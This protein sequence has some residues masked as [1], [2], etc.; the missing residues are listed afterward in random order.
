[1]TNPEPALHTSHDLWVGIERND[2]NHDVPVSAWEAMIN[3]ESALMAAAEHDDSH[4]Q[5][6]EVVAQELKSPVRKLIPSELTSVLVHSLC[7]I[8]RR[9]FDNVESSI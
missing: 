7:D 8:L 3:D 4:V 2:A 9:S 5:H 6:E 1:M